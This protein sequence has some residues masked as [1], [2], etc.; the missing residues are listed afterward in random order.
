MP[1]S[2][3]LHRALVLFFMP[4]LPA[5]IHGEQEHLVNCIYRRLDPICLWLASSL[6]GIGALSASDEPM[7]S[8]QPPG[9]FETADD[10]TPER[11]SI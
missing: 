1:A 5:Q 8:Q 4:A 2:E 6:L 11:E 7:F 10:Q 9:G 3:I